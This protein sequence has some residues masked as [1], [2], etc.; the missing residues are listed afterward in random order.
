M[1]AAFLLMTGQMVVWWSGWGGSDLHR[2]L[3]A[4]GALVLLAVLWRTRRDPAPPSSGWAPALLGP[5]PFVA[6]GVLYAAGWL[7]HMGVR[8]YR[9]EF[10]NFDLGIY[11]NVAF[12]TAHGRPFYSSILSH[13]HL[14][15]H[16]SPITGL[17]AP[18]YALKPSVY[19][20]FG[21][22]ALSFAAVPLVL[23]RVCRGLVP[24]RNR[25][26]SCALG[27]S[28]LWGIY[29]AMAAAMRFPF[30][31]TSLAAPW[32]ILAFYFVQRNDWRRAVPVLLLLL[33]CKES[34]SLVWVG[35]GLHVLVRRDAS[36]GERWRGVLL[37]LGGLGAA[38]LMLKGVIPLFREGDWNQAGRVDP[39]ADLRLKLHYVVFLL[40]PLCGLPLL[41]W[42]NGI[43]ALPSILLNLSTGYA[44][45]YSS[46]FQYDD[47]IAPLLFASC[48]PALEQA[49][50]ITSRWR[51]PRRVM[52]ALLSVYLAAVWQLERSPLRVFWDR[53]AGALHVQL[54]ER[55]ARLAA[56]YPHT[57][58][59]VQ[60]HLGPH[61]HRYEMRQ[62]PIH[63]RDCG[64][65]PYR[66]DTLLVLSTNVPRWGFTDLEEC[67]A[68]IEARS[69]F[70]RLP[71]YDPLHVYYVEHGR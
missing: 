25:A 26:F 64:R 12:N 69:R 16:F 45:Q 61:L 68:E 22:Q 65:A 30:H 37:I 18:L 41:S 32:V 3:A 17:F 4:A 52:V 54:N 19:W 10:A 62:F 43:V 5:I 28:L 34:L 1:Q 48:I 33:T 50:L 9:F 42:R 13:S 31:P 27:L 40:I 70:R 46:R 14:G 23:W 21:A 44:P 38:T 7:A 2:G 15:E 55:L 29:P 53:P 58:M 56:E 47:V 35:L 71:E 59:Y 49:W 63:A 8:Y 66:K 39:G 20:L 11:S 36:G 24:D 51:G 67:I 57:W 6:L 60:S